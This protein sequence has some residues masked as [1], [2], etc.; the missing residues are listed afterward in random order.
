MIGMWTRGIIANRVRPLVVAAAGI[1]CATALIGVIGVFGAASSRSMTQRA[2]SAVP[3]DWQIA[4]APGA[5]AAAL[6]KLLPESGPI[7]A[8]RTVGFA[9]VSGFSAITGD[10]TQSTGAGVVLGVPDDYAATFP[11]QVRG[12]L[13]KAAGVLVAQQ[14]AANLHVTL[15]DKVWTQK[16]QKY[17]ARSL[18][19]LR[20]KYAEIADKAALDPVLEAAGCL[21]GLRG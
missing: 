1:V 9:R 20:A 21:A 13:G 18:S 3:V 10:T 8:A 6:T 14:A 12:L 16:P 11:D 15:G 2:L 17:H 5:D 19:T 7:R 4:L